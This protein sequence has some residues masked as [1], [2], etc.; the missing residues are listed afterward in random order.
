MSITTSSQHPFV[1]IIICSDVCVY[2]DITDPVPMM[3]MIFKDDCD[4]DP[5]VGRSDRLEKKIYPVMSGGP[6]KQM[7]H[8]V[9]LQPINIQISTFGVAG[10]EREPNL[11][12]FSENKG[13]NP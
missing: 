9:P 10:H 11:F 13:L 4:P 2:T 1:D 5:F 6:T 7:N 8:Q 12:N 3:M